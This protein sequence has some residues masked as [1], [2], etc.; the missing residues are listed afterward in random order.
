M[1]DNSSFLAGFGRL[2][3]GR[4]VS[5]LL[6]FVVIPL[7]VLAVLLLPP[8]QVWARIQNVG[9]TAITPTQPVI[10]DPDGTVVTFPA[11]GLPAGDRVYARL[12]SVPRA[13][14][15]RG[16]AGSEM[17]QAAEAL[18]GYLRP[19]SPIYEIEVRGDAPSQTSAVVPIPNE[20]LPYETL[21]VYN[22][23]G[24]SWEWLP[25]QINLDDETVNIDTN[26]VPNAFTVVQT[27]PQAPKVGVK[28]PRERSL[29]EEAVEGT[30]T[31]FADV[32]SLRGDGSVDGALDLPQT[33][34]PYET[35]IT[36]RNYEGDGVPRTDLM[37]NLLIDE[38]LQEININTL[39]ELAA[40]QLY[41]GVALDYRGVDPTLRADYSQFIAKLASRLHQDGKKLAVFV[42]TPAQVS[43]EDWETYG[44]DWR[45]LGASADAIVV[46][47]PVNPLAYATDGEAERLL[48][49]AVGEVDRNKIQLRIPARTVEQSDNYFL[50]RGYGESLAPLTG[51]PTLTSN[52][53]EP[54]GA[55]QADLQ[56]AIVASPLQF[57]PATGI[58]W[59]R[60]RGQ[61]GE[62]RIVFL[63]DAASLAHKVALAKQFNLGGV[64][65]ESL[66]SD[67]IDPQTWSVL[68][69]FAA[70]ETPS[71]PEASQLSLRWTL[72]DE[73]GAVVAKQ[74]SALN[75]EV[76]LAMPA[77]PG[78]Y[79]VEA[80]L[81]NNNEPI[82]SQGTVE[83]AVA[84]LT[85]TATPT[86]EIP[87]TPTPTLTPTPPPYA[88]AIAN[89][90]TNLRAG[91]GTSFA[92]AGLLR[93]GQQ[94]KILGKNQ[95]GSWWQVESA[96]GKPAWIIA[97]RVR[98]SGPVAA[99][100]VA[101]DIPQAP[102]G[103]CGRGCRRACCASGLWRRRARACPLRRRFLRLRHSNPALWRRRQQLLGKRYQGHGLQ[104]GQVAGALEGHGR[105]AWSDWL[106]RPGRPYQLL[107]R[108]GVEHPDVGR[109]GS[110]LGATGQYR[111]RGGRSARRPPDLRQLP[112]RLR[113]TLLRQG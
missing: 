51:Q 73:Q 35:F 102:A 25:R 23:N 28:E 65:V 55:V 2:L 37:A 112:G 78:A 14:F 22:W 48:N 82:A 41:A 57:D 11:E 87:P 103:A 96:N 19:R 49:W 97:N 54:G 15:E 29:P 9:R 7:L 80:E 63:E 74:T 50:F 32:L 91:P 89:G 62:E 60:Y 18:P 61:S 4:N 44:Y 17:R 86:P 99:I 40:S 43:Q 94:L 110:Q 31:V 113:R 109:Q 46:P 10:S 8:I 58:S 92:T 90:D 95:D 27:S 42:E 59:Y 21:D 33:S 1:Q 34:G 98:A 75:E 38:G 111:L 30:T 64:L 85:P 26:F 20:S 83:V 47:G 100:A 68:R 67:D 12:N 39:A 24:Q 6:N 101:K 16:D 79:S 13:D 72:K 107:L 81:L 36:V 56:S 104:L 5:R 69:S 108:P 70:G 45:A 105:L 106:G 77:T 66:L 76:A 52:V 3:E 84:T 93:A 53:V 88:V 71:L